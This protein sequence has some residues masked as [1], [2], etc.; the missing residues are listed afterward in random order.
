MDVSI[1][2]FQWE[3]TKALKDWSKHE[4]P[5]FFHYDFPYQNEQ[6][7]EF[8]YKSKRQFLK[9]WIYAVVLNDQNV[10]GYIT[11]K[12]VQW[13][14][15][16]GEMGIVLN[17]RWTGRGI[18][19]KAIPLYLRH[20]Y[21]HFPI[22]TVRLQVAT[23]NTKAQKCYSAVGFTVVGAEEKPYEEQEFACEILRNFP[24][25]KMKS[26]LLYAG[27]IHMEFAKIDFFERYAKNKKYNLD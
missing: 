1:R 2:S 20:I 17:P 5:R 13:L 7:M 23:F 3:D 9:R 15:K 8:W 11:F 12:H 4:D 25:F 24:H 19:K 10:V 27:Y 14:K 16:T 26:G 21:N 18:G 22:K 6:D